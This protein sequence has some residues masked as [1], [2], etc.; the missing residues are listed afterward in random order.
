M[1]HYNSLLGPKD[2]NP[3]MLSHI[4]WSLGE[5]WWGRLILISGDVQG[6]EQ[7][8]QD[9]TSCAFRTHITQCKDYRQTARL[10][11]EDT[12]WISLSFLICTLLQDIQSCFWLGWIR[13]KFLQ[14]M[15]WNQFPAVWTWAECTIKK[16]DIVLTAFLVS[17][18]NL[19]FHLL[20]FIRLAF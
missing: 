14:R 16:M 17:N 18:F 12:E 5:G 13:F 3:Y 10:L 2:L 4:M 8:C 9:S 7:M 19:S 6:V 15:N 20:Y 1:I 11:R